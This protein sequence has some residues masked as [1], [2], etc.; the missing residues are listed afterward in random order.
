MANRIVNSA[1]EFAYANYNIENEFKK[2]LE[3]FFIY[4]NIVV[5]DANYN[6]GLLY[7]KLEH[8]TKCNFKKIKS[9]DQIENFEVVDCIIVVDCNEINKIKS[10]CKQ[11]SIPYII[12]LTKICDVSNFKNYYFDNI[13]DIKNCN[14]PL[15]IMLDLNSI[16]NK[17]EFVLLS[18]LEVSSV[19]FDI[20]QKKLDSLFFGKQIEYGSLETEKNILGEL[21]TILEK[22]NENI[23]KF[24]KKVADLYL[25]YAISC[26]KDNFNMLDNLINLYKIQNKK[27]VIEAK[28][29]L[30]LII[31]SLEKN[32]IDYYSTGFKNEI[33]YEV[34]EKY[35][36]EFGLSFDLKP[37]FFS[38]NKI[39]YL[40]KEFKEKLLE[41]ITIN[42]GFDKTIKAVLAEIDVDFLYKMIFNF[43][44]QT[45]TN[46][47]CLE[48]D[49]F[50]TPNFLKIMYGFGLLNF[51]I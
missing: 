17:N 15:G 42:I 37:T 5:I 44:N 41:Y 24:A 40:L 14:F 20:T 22:R 51:E 36:K 29:L 32:F 11:Y 9:I 19:C 33:D 25:L 7:D 12:A 13:K 4:Q 45:L 50:K 10:V 38:E 31:T 2:E 48:P 34:H 27:S 30:R 21:E 46:Y 35:L 23:E 6:F 47:I 16:Y 3:K 28:Y 18:V 1:I 43:K 39:N 26:A 49:I 8:S